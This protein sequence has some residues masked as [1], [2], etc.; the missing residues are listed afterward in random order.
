MM[1]LSK[2]S[3]KD[4]G[5]YDSSSPNIDL[6]SLFLGD[7]NDRIASDSPPASPLPSTAESEVS[8]VASNVTS[9][10]EELDTNVPATNAGLPPSP[11]RLPLQWDFDGLTI[12][13]ELEEFDNDMT[14]AIEYLS[15][16]HGTEVIPKSHMTA[17]YGMDHISAD[18]A[19][20][21]LRKI[22]SR[23]K[24]GSW[25]KFRRPVGV[26][27]DIAVAGN[28][29]QVCSVAWGELTLTSG[30]DHEKAL[31]VVYDVM[32]GVGVHSDVEGGSASTR[33]PERHRP[34][35]PHNSLCYDNPEGT[36][37]TLEGVLDAVVRFPTLLTKERSVNAL[38]L[39]ST[40]GKMADWECLERVYLR[41][42]PQP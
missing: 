34:W 36:P 9:F 5:G 30:P 15:A 2:M 6:S 42:E 17:I 4:R 23:L 14:K 31:D 33:T 10:S 40:K 24:H 38:S 26:K 28:P 27:Q 16:A 3:K 12:W 1:H 20:A 25:P 8:S 35:T 22:P 18:E 11:E 41:K 39:W 13:V 29:G 19:C 7:E 21:R 32:Y 37:L